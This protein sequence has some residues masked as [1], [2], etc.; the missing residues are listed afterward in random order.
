MI[1]FVLNATVNWV[2]TPDT[3]RLWGYKQTAHCALCKHPQ[4]TLH[5]IISNC[6]HA[7]NGGR[8]TWRHDSVL[9]YIKQVMQELIDCANT[10]P[11]K[12]TARPPIE[13]SFVR[14]GKTP[15]SKPKRKKT[16]LLDGATDWKLLV[17]IGNDKIVYPP[18][19]YGTPQRPIVVWSRQIKRVLNIELTCPAEEGIAAAKERKEACYFKLNCAAKDRGWASS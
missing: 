4:C 18:E 8:Y 2:K 5:H 15:A 11:T 19:I 13:K 12:D 7:L 17:E 6:P 14:A 3:M 16:T 1:K 9:Q 10:T